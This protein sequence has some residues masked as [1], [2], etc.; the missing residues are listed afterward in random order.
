MISGPGYIL[1]EGIANA[2]I[3]PILGVDLVVTLPA[4]ATVDRVHEQLD[5]RGVTHSVI[6]TEPPDLL[7]IRVWRQDADRAQAILEALK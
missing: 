4:G 7:L 2:V 5:R 1:N 3:P 6:A